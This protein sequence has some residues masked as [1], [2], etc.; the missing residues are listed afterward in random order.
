[1]GAT[2]SNRQAWSLGT[3]LATE[4]QHRYGLQPPKE[5]RPKT[6]GS[7]SH[8][9]ATYPR[10]WI[11]LIRKAIIASTSEQQKQPPLFSETT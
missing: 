4:H 2:L 10:S 3:A 9:F 6:S 7:G 5:L 8:C 11:P 1:M